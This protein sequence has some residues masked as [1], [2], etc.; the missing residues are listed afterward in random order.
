[1]PSATTLTLL[2][3]DAPV[4]IVKLRSRSEAGRDFGNVDLIST[5]LLHLDVRRPLA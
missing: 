4:I 1:M 5:R 3:Q 2:V